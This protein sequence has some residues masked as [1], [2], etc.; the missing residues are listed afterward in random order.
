MISKNNKEIR[1]TLSKNQA[2]WLEKTCKLA[3]ITKSQYISWIMM[4]KAEEMLKVLNLNTKLEVISEDELRALLNE[5][6]L[7]K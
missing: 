5:L 1:I 7:K 3:G 6:D 4:K 2:N